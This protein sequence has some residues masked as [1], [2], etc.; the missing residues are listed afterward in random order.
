MAAPADTCMVMACIAVV[1]IVVAFAAMADVVMAYIAMPDMAMAYNVMAYTVMVFIA[2]V[3]VVVT[4]SRK[5]F[6]PIKQLSSH[7][8]HSYIVS[9]GLVQSRPKASPVEPGSCKQ[10]PPY[11]SSV[12]TCADSSGCVQT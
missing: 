12:T 6:S 3:H 8:W 10:A 7:D 9:D 11:A 1:H 2:A 5:L 4:L